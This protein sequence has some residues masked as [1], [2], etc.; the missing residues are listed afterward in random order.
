MTDDVLRFEAAGDHFEIGRLP[1]SKAKSI[2]RELFA[3][4][5]PA[6]VH[7]QAE[8]YGAAVTALAEALDEARLE[9]WESAIG[10]VTKVVESN[11]NDFVLADSLR[12]RY[13]DRKGAQSLAVWLEWLAKG[14]QHNFGPF[15]ET[16]KS[17]RAALLEG[18]AAKGTPR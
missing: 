3:A 5:G 2:L 1:F 10:S 15:F 11:G 7:A 14:M 17:E 13:F 18:P 9:R 8:Q 12:A 4:G 16:L 6:L